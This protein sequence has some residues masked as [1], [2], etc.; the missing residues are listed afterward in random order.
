M[1][2][3]RS[4]RPAPARP[5]DALEFGP[6]GL[7][8]AFLASLPLFAAYEWGIAGGAPRNSAE[9]LVGRAFDLLGERADLARRLALLA[10]ALAAL[11][12]LLARREEERAPLPRALA[13]QLGEGLLAALC[14]GPLLVGALSVF[15]VSLA[16]LGTPGPR[17]GAPPP[18]ELLARVAGGAAWE[19]LVFRLAAYGIVFLAVV[20]LAAFFGV[21]AASAAPAGDL[22]ALLATSVFFAAFHLD[23]L[24]RPLGAGGEPF[25]RGVFLWRLLAGLCLAALFRWRGLAVAAWA[26][27]IFNAALLLGAGPGVFAG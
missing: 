25:E 3:R 17:P 12:V 27:G 23:L 4:R 5:G 21:A 13:R 19:E 16:A 18:L 22:A 20:R 1:S 15:H 8:A 6:H 11:A 24:T 10:A 7:A 26:H 9:L 14:L 2:A